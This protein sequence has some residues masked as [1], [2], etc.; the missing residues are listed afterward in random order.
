MFRSKKL[1]QLAR[2]ATVCTSCLCVNDGTVVMAHSN[3]S[4]DG[5]GMGLKAH[6]YRV[7]AVCGDCHMAI[8]QSPLHT[9]EHRLAMW[10][11]AHMETMQWLVEDGLIVPTQEN[12]HGHKFSYALFHPWD[13]ALLGQMF[14]DGT[15][16][17]A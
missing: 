8:D 14:D 7:A 13:R 12:L 16:V 5:K 1:L 3:Q 15:L 11:F 10:E 6:D 9:R 4:R 17:V 2:H